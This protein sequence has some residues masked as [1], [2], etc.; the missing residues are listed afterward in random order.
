MASNDAVPST[1]Y[2]PKLGDYVDTRSHGKGVVVDAGQGAVYHFDCN[3]GHAGGFD[4]AIVGRKCYWYSSG[5]LRPLPGPTPWVL[6]AWYDAR[7]HGIAQIVE[8]AIDGKGYI[9]PFP[10]PKGQGDP[11]YHPY[12]PGYFPMVYGPTPIGSKPKALVDTEAAT[13]KTKP[14]ESATPNVAPTT[15]SFE[16]VLPPGFPME[17]MPVFL[18]SARKIVSAGQTCPGVKCNDCPSSKQQGWPQDCSDSRRGLS[19]DFFKQ[20]LNQ[21][22]QGDESGD[23]TKPTKVLIRPDL[24]RS[25]FEVMASESGRLPINKTSAPTVTLHRRSIIVEP[26]PVRSIPTVSLHRPSRLFT[27]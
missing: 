12:P 14:V 5:Q 25:A 19:I 8:I 21:F 24:A 4:P 16:I 2:V 18:E 27:I 20:F 22:D 15:P 7:A 13:A 1:P 17:K 3:N 26:P 11:Q 23:E 10:P 6:G 9:S